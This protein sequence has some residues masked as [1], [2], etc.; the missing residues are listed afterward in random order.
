M[1]LKPDDLPGNY[2]EKNIER[3]RKLMKQLKHLVDRYFPE[4]I[5]ELRPDEL[6]IRLRK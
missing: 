2:R 4:V 1:R 3:G 6:V 5:A